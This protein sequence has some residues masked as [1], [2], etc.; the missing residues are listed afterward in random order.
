METGTRKAAVRAL[1][2]LRQGWTQ[3]LSMRVTPQ[4]DGTFHHTYCMLGANYHACNAVEGPAYH[5]LATRLA[6]AI[7]AQ[8]PDMDFEGLGD[9]T[10]VVQFNDDESTTQDQVTALYEKILAE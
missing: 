9:A 6:A 8:Y 3:G 5:D 7:R 1:R 10:T 2:L 4:D